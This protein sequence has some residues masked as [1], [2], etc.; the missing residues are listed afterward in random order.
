MEQPA[1][2]SCRTSSTARIKGSTTGQRIRMYGCENGSGRCRALVGGCSGLSRTFLPYASFSFSPATSA[3]GTH[4]HRLHAM[5][6]WK[7]VT[8]TLACY[9]ELLSTLQCPERSSSERYTLSECFFSGANVPGP[10]TFTT[11][12]PSPTRTKT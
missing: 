11:V 12:S 3:F 8:G 4:I 7:T 2:R 1:R 5:V 9:A 10:S 6:E